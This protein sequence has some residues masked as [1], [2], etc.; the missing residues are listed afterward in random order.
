MKSAFNNS[1]KHIDVVIP[2]HE[3]DSDVIRLCVKGCFKNIVGLRNI[4]VIGKNITLHSD[5]TCFIDEDK[6]FCD[7]LNKSYI[8][9]KW[10]EM[11]VDNLKISGWLFQQFIKLGASYA[12]ENLSDNYVVVDADVI[13][14]R[15]REFFRD[16]ITLL[17]YGKE[18]FEPDYLC[19]EELL[20]QKVFRDYSFITH[21]IPM[22]KQLVTEMLEEIEKRFNKKWY[23]AIIECFADKNLRFSEYQLYGQFLFGR[24]KDKVRLRKLNYLQ[25]YELKYYPFIYFGQ[26]DY[27]VFHRH[28]NPDV[29][30]N[31]RRWRYN[32]FLNYACRKVAGG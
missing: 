7:G 16:S 32:L 26:F 24:H 25:K 12:I 1:E 9:D 22:N 17:S 10:R 31:V 3:K 6:L 28:K 4:Y 21:H 5:K 30:K 2:Y 13:F 23:D 14:L 20:G 19:C 29:N 11:G 27:I 8:E 15:P 18:R